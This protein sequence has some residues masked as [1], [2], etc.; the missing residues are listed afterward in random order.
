[1]SGKISVNIVGSAATVFNRKSFE[2]DARPGMTLRDLLAGLA[3][4]AGPDYGAKAYDP[5][6]GRVNEHLVVF[7]NAREARMLRGPDT[8]LQPG[9]VVTIMPP[10]A[11]GSPGACPRGVVKK[12]GARK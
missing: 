12:V 8:A 10:M 2:V 6:T 3:A 11:G 4:G 1:M 9:D 5:A 7:V